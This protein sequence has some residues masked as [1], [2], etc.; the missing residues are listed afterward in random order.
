MPKFPIVDTH[1]HV[2][3]PALLSYPWLQPIP[4]LNKPYLLADY[5]RACAPVAVEKMVFIQAEADF[6][7]YR[8]ETAWVT[9]L[10]E[11]DHRLQGIVSW[12]PLE[13]GDAVRGE[14]EQL[15]QNSLVKGIRRIIQFEP[16]I[17]FCLRPGFVKGVQALPDYG[18]SF[19]IC[20]MHLQLA[21][22]IELVRQC[23]DVRFILDHIGKPD[24]KHHF[25]Q[26]WKKQL[27][28]LASFPNVWCKMSGLAT[29]ADHDNWTRDDLRPFIDHVINAFGFERV[30]FG[31]DFP[32]VLQASPWVRWVETLEWALSGC[33]EDELLKVF[34]TNANAF[35]RLT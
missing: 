28:T 15:A 19:D 8:E 25:L 16:D 9:A 20:V 14:L 23:P 29:E 26:P 13:N 10:A 11:Q 33:S 18:L 1:L 21:N 7:Q 6:A 27:S 2:W 5:D 32:V 24:I 35:Y 3:D 34:C 4:L 12:A 30:M 31:G 17:A 22:T